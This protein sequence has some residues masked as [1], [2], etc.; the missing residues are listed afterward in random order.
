MV[1]GH[2]M[3]NK[4]GIGEDF[5]ITGEKADFDL[6]LSGIGVLVELCKVW[7]R[8]D[9]IETLGITKVGDEDVVTLPPLIWSVCGERGG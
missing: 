6:V 7:K 8:G 5:G 4:S 2:L 3:G 9:E 1:G